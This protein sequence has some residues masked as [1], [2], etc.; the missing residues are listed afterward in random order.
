M[1][2]KLTAKQEAFAVAYVETGIGAAAYRRAYNAG[3]MSPAN[4]W[5]RASELLA[6]GK[7]SARVRQL[8][9]EIAA[10]AGITEAR[11]LREIAVLAFGTLDMV[12]PWDAQ[13]PM[14]IPSA[15]LPPEKRALVASIKVKRR[16]RIEL[17]SDDEEM[18]EIEDIE[19]KP[20]DKVKALD[21]LMKKMGSYAP[22]RNEHSGPDGGPI[23]IERRYIGVDVDK[24]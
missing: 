19:I 8:Q 13:G 15:D 2:E 7:V 4:I 12:A 18:W 11:L 10:A 22:I 3:K 23:P 14:L 1:S 6:D 24:V 17:G 5:S 21:M 20:W 9:D 16:R